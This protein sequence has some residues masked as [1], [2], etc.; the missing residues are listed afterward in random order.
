MARA[1]G[2][3][4]IPARGSTLRK[5]ALADRASGLRRF[6]GNRVIATPVN[7]SISG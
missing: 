1:E 3:P 5:F 6:Y 2:C 4:P 7:R